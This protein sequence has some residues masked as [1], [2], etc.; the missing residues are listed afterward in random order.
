MLT[1]T[2]SS[3]VYPQ[4][5]ILQSGTPKTVANLEV[6]KVSLLRSSLSPSWRTRDMDGPKETTGKKRRG[7]RHDEISRYE[8]EDKGRRRS[9]VEYTLQSNQGCIIEELQINIKACSFEFYQSGL[10]ITHTH[11]QSIGVNTSPSIHTRLA[12]P[13]Y[14]LNPCRRSPRWRR[15][16]GS[17]GQCLW[18]WGRQ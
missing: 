6:M 14:E 15:R 2:P 8:D 5:V 1:S 7:R 12:L 10:K 16:R 11:S 13:S 18:L 17:L 4:R 3:P 9:G